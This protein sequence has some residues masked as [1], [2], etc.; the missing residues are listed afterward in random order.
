M[1][2]AIVLLLIL[3]A[4]PGWA[5]TPAPAPPAVRPVVPDRTTQQQVDLADRSLAFRAIVTTH[6]LYDGTTPDADIVTTAFLLDSV[7]AAGRPVTFAINGGPGA[8]SAWLDLLAM[9]PWRVVL[10]QAAELSP[11]LDPALVPNAETWLG[12]TD[13]VFIDPPG[14]GYSRLLNTGDATRRKYYAA[15]GDVN[16]IATVMRRWLEAN[17]RRASPILLVGESYGGFRGPRLARRLADQEGVALRGLMLVSPILDF[18]ASD[19]EWQPYAWLT[20][21]PSMA[22]ANRHGEVR[23]AEA[24][25]YATGEYLVDFMRGRGDA[26]AVA[27]MVSRVTALTGLDPELVRRRGGR[28]DWWTY[29]REHD[30]GRIASAYDLSV[31]ALDPVPT[32]QFV[33]VPDAM[34]DVLKAPVAAAAAS[35]YADKLGWRPDGAPGPRYEILS[36]SVFP[37]WNYG[38]GQLAAQSVGA[39]RNAIAIDPRLQVVVLHGLYDLVTPYFASKLI[40]DQLSPGVAQRAKLIVLPGGHMFYTRDASRVR[41]QQ[42][43]EALVK[44]ALQP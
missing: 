20:R 23:D 8:G 26:E 18:N 25:A 32:A 22:A 30:A 17:G 34:T 43:G 14:T 6:R 27:R 35:L 38:G 4:R 2:L 9:G 13:L 7:P 16:A 41:L 33:Q 1:R 10:P 19:S 5:Q 15:E 42:E 11:S 24:E 12:F 3:F 31:T 28:I 29:R 37:Q 40:L 44:S 21:L 39:L 36:E